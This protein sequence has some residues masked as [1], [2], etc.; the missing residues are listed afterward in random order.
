MP[1]STW[2]SSSQASRG[3]ITNGADMAAHDMADAVRLPRINVTIE[4]IPGV[5]G[6]AWAA[7]RGA[8]EPA[9]RPQF[10]RVKTMA[11]VRTDKGLEAF[12]RATLAYWLAR[13]AEFFKE[14]KRD[15]E[16]TVRPPAW[17]VA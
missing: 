12:T 16:K 8:T 11:C 4:R 6:E 9:E 10:V 2:P 14:T 7:L 17:L 1:H 5:A 15:G 3:F 13:V